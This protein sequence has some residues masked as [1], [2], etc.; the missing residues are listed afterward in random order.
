MGENI[1]TVHISDVDE[2]G[3]IKLPGKGVFDFEEL[4][5]RLKDVG[6]DGSA[7]IEVYKDD[8]GEIKEIGESLDRMRELAYKIF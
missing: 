1:R 5:T 4:F 2:N 6:F 3:K 7:L 8:Y